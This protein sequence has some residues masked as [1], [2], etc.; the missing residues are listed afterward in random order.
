MEK[1]SKLKADSS[2]A[3]A[4]DQTKTLVFFILEENKG[5]FWLDE[6]R[7]TTIESRQKFESIVFQ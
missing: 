3:R 7:E 5:F 2:P 6:Y 1:K 4:W